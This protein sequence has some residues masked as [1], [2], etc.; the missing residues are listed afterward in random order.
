MLPCLYTSCP[1]EG[2]WQPVLELRSK[3]NGIVTLLR[4]T[5][6]AVC[7]HHQTSAEVASFLSLEGF[8]KLVRILKEAGKQTPIRKFTT[9]DWQQIT[10]DEITT[11]SPEPAFVRV[12][13]RLT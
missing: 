1:N 11:F 6:I 8:D 10:P 9:L 5:A 4:F 12:E 7:G 13:E 3:Q 2:T